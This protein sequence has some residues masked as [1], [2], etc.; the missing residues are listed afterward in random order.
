M[1]ARF[2]LRITIILTTLVVLFLLF[3]LGDGIRIGMYHL[4]SWIQPG[5]FVLHPQGAFL[6]SDGNIWAPTVGA[7]IIFFIVFSA[8]ISFENKTYFYLAPIFL[9][10]YLLF[11]FIIIYFS[12]KLEFESFPLRKEWYAAFGR[13]DLLM[14]LYAAIIVRL[15]LWDYLQSKQLRNYYKYIQVVILFYFFYSILNVNF[16]SWLN[17]HLDPVN[18]F[19]ETLIFFTSVLLNLF[20]YPTTY[21]ENILAIEHSRGI[22][23]GFGCLGFSLMA[24]FASFVLAVP[25]SWKHKIWFIPAGLIAIQ[26]I[27]IIRLAAMAY[28]V[29]F[30][31]DA[32]DDN[33]RIYFK[34]AVYLLTFVLWWI[35]IR[36]FSTLRQIESRR[37][38]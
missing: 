12:I 4:F 34:Y 29:K 38:T 20:A 17:V 31:P 28:T 3:P 16:V 2:Y 37:A 21:H 6:L 19:S 9:L 25:G 32:F 8:C 13:R 33:H 30:Y 5:V 10:F 26:F 23:L 18:S 27:N 36:R 35:Y 22:Y 24:L 14:L 15:Q 1:N 11:Q 7:K